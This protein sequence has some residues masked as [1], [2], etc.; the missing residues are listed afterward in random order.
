MCVCVCVWVSGCAWVCVC[1]CVCVC[2]WVVVRGCV[3]MYVSVC[4]CMCMQLS[5]GHTAP[6]SSEWVQSWEPMPW[7]WHSV[8][9]DSFPMHITLSKYMGPSPWPNVAECRLTA[10]VKQIKYLPPLL[11]IKILLLYTS[12]PSEGSPSCVQTT[13]ASTSSQ[14]SS[15]TV[16]QIPPK[17]ISTLPRPKFPPSTSLISVSLHSVPYS[18][19]SR[20]TSHT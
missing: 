4:V 13:D 19:C 12:V 6:A 20:D 14:E 15:H 11:V 16:P 7:C 10:P 9:F 1:V 2:G 17:Q 3:C 5:L 18:E 8:R